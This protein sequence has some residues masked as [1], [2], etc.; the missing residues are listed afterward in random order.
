MPFVNSV[1]SSFG[2]AGRFQRPAN[3]AKTE[4]GLVTSGLVLSLDAK[5]PGLSPLTQWQDGSGNNRNFTF[6]NT[7]TYNTSNAGTYSM[8]PS[9]GFYRPGVI[10]NATSC[11]LQFW[12]RT[13]EDNA[14]FWSGEA[15]GST[16]GGYYVGAY[17]AGVQQYHSPMSPPDVFINTSQTTTLRS[18]IIASSTWLF[19]EFK[20]VNFSDWPNN[21]FNDYGG[22]DFDAGQIGAVFMYNR[23]LSSGE[24]LQNYNLLRG[25]YGL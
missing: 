7:P 20:N 8:S 12:I 24:S 21:K 18:T 23:T 14:L 13:N 15:F 5:Y 16:G 1:R 25:R 10:T 2:S 19:V 11:T 3:A 22:F 9:T 6:E 4:S 17:N